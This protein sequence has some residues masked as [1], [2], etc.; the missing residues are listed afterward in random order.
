[1]GDRHNVGIRTDGH[2]LFIYA[3]NGFDSPAGYDAGFLKNV[4]TALNSAKPRWNDDAYGT[5]IVTSRL[6]NGAADSVLGYGISIDTVHDNEHKIP[7]IDWET[8]RVYLTEDGRK[9]TTIVSWTF[10]E[11]V[12]KYA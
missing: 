2:V 11:F 6:L 12:Q 7:V 3:H 4:A 9:A 10:D 1:M 5:R 8:Q